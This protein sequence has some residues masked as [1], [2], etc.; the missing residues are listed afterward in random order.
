MVESSIHMT[1]LTNLT[2][3]SETQTRKS[4]GLSKKLIPSWTY[5]GEVSKVRNEK[6]EIKQVPKYWPCPTV[7][8]QILNSAIVKYRQK[9]IQDNA[10]EYSRRRCPLNKEPLAGHRV[11]DRVISLFPSPFRSTTD[12]STQPL[13]YEWYWGPRSCTQSSPLHSLKL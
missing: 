11:G 5:T 12:L 10:M 9:R 6:S 2:Q 3:E 7:P 1:S 13:E 4:K 8:S